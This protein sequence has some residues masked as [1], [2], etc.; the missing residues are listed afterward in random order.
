MDYAPI[1]AAMASVLA[2]IE[3]IRH[4]QPT[5]ARTLCEELIVSA[6]EL[7]EP[8]AQ[9]IA[10]E[11]YGQ[12]MDHEG[13]IL[14]ARDLLFEAT[15]QAMS[16]HDTSHEARLL[17]TIARSYYSCG[18]YRPALQYWARCVELTENANTEAKTWMLAK[19][20]L[21]QIYDALGDPQSAVT[22]HQAAAERINEDYDAYLDAKILINLGVNL[23]KCLRAADAR[24][25]LTKALNICLEH[26]YNDY[27]AEAL[28]RLAEINLN[29]QAAQAA[30]AQLEQALELARVV[31]YRWG[32]ANIL[33]AMADAHAQNGE[34]QKALDLAHIG[35]DIAQ[36]NGFL[37]I[38][39]RLYL[40]AARYAESVYNA[41][42]A[43]A[44]LKAGYECQ[45]KIL[46][47]AAPEQKQELEQKTGLRPSQHK[48]LID[49]SNQPEI[50]R[51]RLDD[52]LNAIT[53]EGSLIISCSRVSF[54][55]L[56]ESKQKLSCLKLFDTASGEYIAAP[57]PLSSQ[58][59]P[60]F[61]NWLQ[62]ANPLIAH[63]AVHHFQAWELSEDYLKP[64]KI[65]SFMAFPIRS[66][67]FING[68][69]MFDQQFAQRNWTPDDVQH[70]SQIGDITTR[71][72][73]NNERR[74]F[75]HEIH[76]LN[77]KLQEN[78]D[79]LE[80]R[81]EHRTRELARRNQ[82]LQVAM[83]K[84]VQSEKLAALGSLV[85]GIAHELNTP[86]GA[87]LTSASVLSGNSQDLQNKLE[88]NS[89]KKTE[90][91]DFIQIAMS[92]SGLIERN[93]HRASDLVGHFKQVA[94]DTASSRRRE[95][96]LAE[97]I[98]EVVVMLQPQL[99]VTQHRVEHQ[100]PPKILLDSY[101]GP[102]EQ[103]L[104]NLILN[105]LLHAFEHIEAGRMQLRYE[106]IDERMIR[107]IYE[108][109]GAGMSAEVQKHVF[110]PFFTTKLGKG[111]S[112]LGLY[113]V[114]NLV[115]GVL[116]GDLKLESVPNQ[117][118]RFIITIPKIAPINEMTML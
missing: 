49:L 77:A 2:Q 16:F 32:E 89:L 113:I 7:R 73:A 88:A 111:G 93:L 37:H 23:I 71:A 76:M 66:S 31:R 99:K 98:N 65:V 61:F 3:A 48:L 24:E 104:S 110:D 101:P 25:V 57:P 97:T 58:N 79:D 47:N 107:I 59:Y 5:Q 10:T 67:G 114:Y 26:H 87:A 38:L 69:L 118:T 108:D 4:E 46:S 40:A 50:E 106:A 39:A 22:L 78:N 44:E 116:G 45:Q 96:D 8:L 29:Q 112:G 33:G 6:R 55:Q 30:L 115:N 80:E 105:S 53:R 70:G 20:G 15:Q 83:E 117:Y 92:A 13:R 52:A 60:G 42:L 12:L 54:W 103:V 41:P 19:V 51:G 68:V 85:A 63:D 94:V 27:A 9:I 75:Q 18:D 100:I 95:F 91:L 17:E 102:L 28:L 1:P 81:V 62:Q 36:E 90:L 34:W 72:I 21:G 74:A 14:E 64:N 86:L 11:I 56:D 82:E 35:Q 43:L 84:L 109:N